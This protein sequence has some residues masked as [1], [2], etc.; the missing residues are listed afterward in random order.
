MTDQINYNT[1]LKYLGQIKN[2][3]NQYPVYDYN[4]SKY[5]N[6]KKTKEKEIKI[7][8]NEIKQNNKNIA[9]VKNN[10]NTKKKNNYNNDNYLNEIENI[11]RQMLNGL[12]NNNNKL[13][14]ELKVLKK[15]S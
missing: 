13:K 5:K 1:H 2:R 15:E 14:S 9:S 4:N 12:I 7:L 8:K 6:N 11:Q 10:L 3:P